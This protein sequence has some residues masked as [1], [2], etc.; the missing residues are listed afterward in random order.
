MAKK[1]KT[2]NERFNTRLN[3]NVLKNYQ[4]HAELFPSLLNDMGDYDTQGFYKNVYNTHKGDFNAITQALTPGSETEHI[5]TDRF[6]KPNHPTFS[7]ESKYHIPIFRPGGYWQDD[8]FVASNRNIRNMNENYGSP[9]NYM[10]WAE[11]YNRNNIP[12]VGLKYKGKTLIEPEQ[13]AYGGKITNM[14]KKK[15]NNLPKYAAGGTP[16][17]G[18]LF[19]VLSGLQQLGTN[20]VPQ[21]DY[22][23]L[24]QPNPTFTG[25]PDSI[26]NYSTNNNPTLGNQN[27]NYSKLNNT[28]NTN[29]GSGLN[30][31][32]NLF[33]NIGSGKGL[34]SKG[35]LGGVMELLNGPL[36]PLAG[37]AMNSVT[38]MVDAIVTPERERRPVLKNAASYT[39][40][41]GGTVKGRKKKK[42][43][44]DKKEYDINSPEYR[45]IFEQGLMPVDEEGLPVSYQGSD[46]AWNEEFEK[47]RKNKVANAVRKGTGK[48]V[49]ETAR[50]LPGNPNEPDT[51]L[52]NIL[53]ITPTPLGR[54]L[55]ADDALLAGHDLFT[56]N[57]EG[58][59]RNVTDILGVTPYLKLGSNPINPQFFTDVANYYKKVKKRNNPI[60]D[61]LP[62]V[63]GQIPNAVNYGIPVEGLM[64]DI[65]QDNIIEQ[66]ANGGTIKIKPSKKGTFTAAAK[67]RG[68]SVQAFA[69][70]V[71][72]NKD[73]YSPAMVKKANFARNAAKWK[74]AVGGMVKPDDGYALASNFTPEFVN[75]P[76]AFDYENGGLVGNYMDAF[77]AMGYGGMINP[78]MAMQQM[79]YG[80]Y[81]QGGQVPQNIPVEVEGEE[82]YEMP[83]GEV[84]EFQGA[85]HENGGMPMALPEGTKIYSDRLKVN[86]KTM[87]ARKDKREANIAKLERLLTKNPNDKFIKEAL[88]RQQETNALEESQD[89]QQQEMVNKQQAQQEQA[90]EQM[91]MG[92]AQQDMQEGMMMA[93]G[94]MIKRAD[95]SYSQRGL[96]DNIRANRGSGKKPTKEMLKQE[97]K[98][99]AAEKAYGG[100]VKYAPGGTVG[101]YDVCPPGY[102]K[103]DN[104]N[105]IPIVESKMMGVYGRINE[106]DKDPFFTQREYNETRDRLSKLQPQVTK[107]TDAPL[108]S[109]EKLKSTYGIGEEPE[110]FTL[111][112]E[113]IS[114]PTIQERLNA[115]SKLPNAKISDFDK[116]NFPTTG[117]NIIGIPE[118]I[119]ENLAQLGYFGQK[120][121]A[122]YPEGYG[123]KGKLPTEFT[124]TYSPDVP[125]KENKLAQFFNNLFSGDKGKQL[126]N[127]KDKDKTIP[128]GYDFTQGDKTGMFGTSVGMY[129][130][131]LMT[132]LNRM[133]TP[134]NQNFFSTFGQDALR[135]QE[136]AEGLAG[137]SKDEAYRK[138][139]MR[140]NALRK[141]LANSARGVNDI[142]S[143]QLSAALTEQEGARGILA[144]YLQGMAGLKGQRA[145][146]Q[147]QIDQTRM[148][149]EQ[150]RDLADRQD[151]DQFYTNLAEN[152]ANASNMMQ[153]QGRDLNVAQYN[154][155]IMSLAKSYS[156]Y[157]VYPVRDPRTGLL[158]LAHKGADGKIT[159]LTEDEV[160][161][162]PNKQSEVTTTKVGG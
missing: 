153:K 79:M 49:K 38:D 6:K 9:M 123:P 25:L 119:N 77:D 136:E 28:N 115:I 60:L 137:I 30:N 33:S 134:P 129:G 35:L 143:G 110:G 133:E 59:Y 93:M 88:K 82:M 84:G 139:L 36:A 57:K 48:F 71:L 131:A 69:S 19:N 154:K 147:Q 65:Y 114:F 14:K 85:K 121:F 34:G 76:A 130:P 125:Q 40:D 47:Q 43:K 52:E 26:Y 109:S 68:K 116:S 32:N 39:F 148:G 146:L 74:K 127:K 15:S 44:V 113:N 21:F 92:A 54:I 108:T 111:I 27:P 135:T 2:Y 55:S 80:S 5:G 63:A 151:I 46:E 157:G 11:D 23:S 142:R 7:K 41:N 155:D 56:G 89:M 90:M 51:F 122:N 18:G 105:C 72:A 161:E 12:D 132:M 16:G 124:E 128:G 95:G 1:K 4:K 126:K 141:Q 24:N 29:T 159:Y 120:G 53:E 117:E 81:A 144:N 107:I 98:I 87:A 140:A 149:G 104:G 67:K 138:N 13:K 94:G 102:E 58:T 96:W 91:L 17:V 118:D 103:D 112:D 50:L 8:Y 150:Q 61:S 10:Q 78:S 75:I 86:G 101:F 22:S 73:N 106:A 70:Q 83:N 31:L 145:N 97:K 62:F 152:V 100:M 3:D 37:M 45:N 158:T 162:L 156:K 160:K 66:K 64:N 20:T 42:V 99:K